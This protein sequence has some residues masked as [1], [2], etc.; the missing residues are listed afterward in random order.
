M[1]VKAV[2]YYRMSSS[3]QEKSIPQQRAEMLPRCKLEGVEILAE[4]KDEGV[5]GGSMK[6]RDAFKEMLPFCKDQH[7]KGAPVAAV[8][9]FDT[10]RFS[11]ATSMETAHFIWEFQQAGVHRVLSW[12]RWFDFRKE[13]DRAIFLL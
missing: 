10:S 7:A 2:A 3:P 11:R 9:C 13:E 6:R 1:P 4:F 5:S 8:V 12:E